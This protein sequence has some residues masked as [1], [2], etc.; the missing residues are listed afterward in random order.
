MI[1]YS[2][3]EVNEM[4]IWMKGQHTLF[5]NMTH[6]WCGLGSVEVCRLLARLAVYLPPPVL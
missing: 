4:V 1:H 5:C 3:I 2:L 6:S